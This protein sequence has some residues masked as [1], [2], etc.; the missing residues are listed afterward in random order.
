MNIAAFVDYSTGYCKGKNTTR[1][2]ST[3]I[4]AVYKL[5][6]SLSPGKKTLSEFFFFIICVQ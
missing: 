5:F 1:T 3:S 6:F 4:K 2:C